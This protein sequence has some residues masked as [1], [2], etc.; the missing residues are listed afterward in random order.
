[1]TRE[2]LE[3]TRLYEKKFGDTI[4]RGY[5]LSEDEDA[6]REAIITG[7]ELSEGNPGKGSILT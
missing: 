4:P 7:K 6:V 1:M 3:V 2:F 5:W